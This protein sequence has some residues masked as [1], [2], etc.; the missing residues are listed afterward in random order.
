[1]CI[2][3]YKPSGVKMPSERLLDM[4]QRLN[5]HGSGFVSS[6]GLYY[7]GLNYQLFKNRLSEVTAKDELI[8]HFRL[9]THGSVKRGNCHPF[10]SMDVYFAHNGILSILPVNDKTDSET[11]FRTVI[12][13]KIKANGLH[14][15]DTE[16]V[17]N[18][19]RGASK[20]AIMQNGIVN[21]YGDFTQINGLY[22]SNTRFLT[23]KI[24]F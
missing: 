5:P 16:M 2:I 6:T 22:F 21:L 12:M 23:S 1:M 18:N 24:S 3:I 19:I 15:E 8:I 14:S 7:K 10:K 20:F 13:P 9:A 4:C 17:I 11:A